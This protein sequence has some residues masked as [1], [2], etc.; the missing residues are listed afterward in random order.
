MSV[1]GNKEVRERC[2]VHC[3]VETPHKGRKTTISAQSLRSDDKRAP[4]E[5]ATELF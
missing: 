3:T 4:F 2:T 1:F 5:E